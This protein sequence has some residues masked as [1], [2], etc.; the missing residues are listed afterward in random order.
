M[1][2]TE[3]TRLEEIPGWLWSPTSA[4]KEEGFKLLQE[5]IDREGHARVP[6]KHIEM[7][8]A[9]GQWVTSRRQTYKRGK[10]L[11]A[12]QLRLESIQGWTWIIR[13]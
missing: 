2:D 13:E 9:L 11:P 12:E 10:M 1:T 5:F 8:F 3:K 4:R 6:A 7:G